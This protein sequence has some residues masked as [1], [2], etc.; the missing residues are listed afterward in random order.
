MD[1]LLCEGISAAECLEEYLV[2]AA[3]NDCEVSVGH[4]GDHIGMASPMEPPY[5]TA[6][7]V[8]AHFKTLTPTA[9]AEAMRDLLGCPW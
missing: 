4:V 5:P 8:R 1:L 3:A 2:E 9:Q 7:E 6:D